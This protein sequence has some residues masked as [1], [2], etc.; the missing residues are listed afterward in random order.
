LPTYAAQCPKGCKIGSGPEKRRF[1]AK[2]LLSEIY[3]HKIYQPAGKKGT[4]GDKTMEDKTPVILSV[5]T[6]FVE[7]LPGLMSPGT[8]VSR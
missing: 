8:F 3:L 4:V 5:L 6:K 1:K 2:I 7:T